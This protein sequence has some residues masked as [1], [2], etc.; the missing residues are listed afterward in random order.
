MAAASS[1]TLVVLVEFLCHVSVLNITQLNNI[2][3]YILFRFSWYTKEHLTIMANQIVESFPLYANFRYNNNLRDKISWL[4]CSFLHVLPQKG[5]RMWDR[6]EAFRNPRYNCW[7]FK[8]QC[9]SH[10]TFFFRYWI[11]WQRIIPWTVT[12]W[13]RIAFTFPICCVLLLWIFF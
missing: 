6:L 7:C 2:H 9:I 4:H 3:L 12:P 1:K 5:L 13:L 10:W 8:D 11:D